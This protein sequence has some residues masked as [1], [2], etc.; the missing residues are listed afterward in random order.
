MLCCER[1]VLWVWCSGQYTDRRSATRRPQRYAAHAFV[2]LFLASVI[3]VC[4]SAMIPTLGIYLT[5]IPPSSNGDVSVWLNINASLAMIPDAK[6]RE[7]IYTRCDRLGQANVRDSGGCFAGILGSEWYHR[8]AH[9]R[10]A[11]APRVLMMALPAL[12][13]LMTTCFSSANVWKLPEAGDQVLGACWTTVV[14]VAIFIVSVS[15]LATMSNQ[16]PE[17]LCPPAFKRGGT[18]S[19]SL[20]SACAIPLNNQSDIEYAHEHWADRATDGARDLG[21]FLSIDEWHLQDLHVG[22]FWVGYTTDPRSPAQPSAQGA[23]MVVQ[24]ATLAVTLPLLVYVLFLSMM[25]VTSVIIVRLRSVPV[26]PAPMPPPIDEP[27]SITRDPLPPPA[28][29]PSM[30]P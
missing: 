8:Y 14:W 23:S 9:G 28:P 26:A 3:C 19:P 25:W 13:A 30:E 27:M 6:A 18:Y 24:Y 10:E 11:M 20:F 17:A 2:F 12:L 29:S 1:R 21:G 4:A 5:Y 15:Q 22:D 7:E 16:P